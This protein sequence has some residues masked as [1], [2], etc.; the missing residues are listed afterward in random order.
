MEV[1]KLI[2]IWDVKLLEVFLS[3]L[4]GEV[5]FVL[6]RFGFDFYFCGVYFGFIILLY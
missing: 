1:L 4:C 3:I 2:E 5:V 6:V